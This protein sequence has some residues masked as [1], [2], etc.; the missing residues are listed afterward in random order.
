MS[1]EVLQRIAK[2]IAD[3]KAALAAGAVAFAAALGATVPS[4]S[5]GGG[6]GAG[7][8]AND[9]ELDSQY[10]DPVV[11]KDPTAR[12]W[13]GAS[14]GG[15]QLSECP[16]DY[17]DAFAKYKDA[18]AYVNEKEGKAEK[19][20]YVEYDRRDAARARG[21]AARLRGGGWK[22]KTG[23]GKGPPVSDEDYDDAGGGDDTP[24]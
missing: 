3:I 11:R 5:S 7:R 17:L 14:Y 24:F 18:C 12:Y 15:C 22:P 13:T 23:G 10:G 1:E 19:Q 21:W 2:D 6:S 4:S 8:V 9:Q 16:P 20:K